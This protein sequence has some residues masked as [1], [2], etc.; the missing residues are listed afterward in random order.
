MTLH[1]GTASSVFDGYLRDFEGVL[2]QAISANGLNF[3]LIG[4]GLGSAGEW[5]AWWGA[6]DSSAADGE[7]SKRDAKFL[8]P[9]ARIAST[10]AP[11]VEPRCHVWHMVLEGLVGWEAVLRGE[12]GQH[13]WVT[14]LL[15]TIDSPK[16]RS[17]QSCD[18]LAAGW[19][20]LREP[21][22]RHKQ[23]E[24][25]S[26][27][28]GLKLGRI[29]P[30]MSSQHISP[31]EGC[32]C[33]FQALD[34]YRRFPWGPL[35]YGP[36]SFSQTRARLQALQIASIDAV[37]IGD[38]RQL[39][40][41]SVNDK[42]PEVESLSAPKSPSTECVVLLP[43][44]S[45]FPIRHRYGIPGPCTLAPHLKTFQSWL[46]SVALTL[47][48][49]W[50]GS[51]SFAVNGLCLQEGGNI[52]SGGDQKTRVDDLHQRAKSQSNTWTN[53]R[54]APS[55]TGRLPQPPATSD[56]RPG[57]QHLNATNSDGFKSSIQPE[58]RQQG[59]RATGD[60]PCENGFRIQPVSLSYHTHNTKSHADR[61]INTQEI[62][63]LV[64]DDPDGGRGLL[65]P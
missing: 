10:I 53:G 43:H 17:Q 35:Q 42:P 28:T 25:M 64:F 50:L 5:F 52:Y 34:G 36:Q 31:L 33:F 6:H 22:G 18:A 65:H 58:I 48:L 19:I 15:P 60:E 14:P 37:R 39:A 20:A 7:A 55:S 12:H 49:S 61:M 45:F 23:H 2:A 46:S 13:G 8:V 63:G 54:A 9:R 40:S 30:R 1:R 24:R 41:P 26:D 29:I 16:L 62:D 38:D 47:R 57:P 32:W 59:Y 21:G 44:P 3:A 51:P 4:M 11:T 56:L 27:P